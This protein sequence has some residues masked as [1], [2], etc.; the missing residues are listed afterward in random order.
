MRTNKDIRILLVDDEYLVANRIKRTFKELGYRNLSQASNGKEAIEKTLEIEPDCIIMDIEMPEM[1]GIEATRIIQEKRPTPVIMLTAY[2]SAALVK[3]ATEAGVSGYLIKPLQTELI[4]RTMM[5]AIAP[6]Q[7]LM[8]V[9]HLNS[10]L[11]KA[12]EE[13][14]ALRGIIPIC[15]EC[16]NI[17][18][19]DG[20][21]Q[22][23]EKYIMEHSRAQFSHSL[24][25]GCAEK[26]YKGQDWYEEMKKN[27]K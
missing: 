15:C 4:D 16:K 3:K 19:D 17:R 22:S 24:C 25:P 18:N 9:R 26:L 14:E 2:K 12:M 6:H 11:K 13:I 20:Y 21:W 8:E 1:S 10:K 27:D 7:D 5:I 23:V